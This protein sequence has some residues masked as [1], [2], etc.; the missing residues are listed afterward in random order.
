MVDKPTLVHIKKQILFIG[1][2]ILALS[3]LAQ[4]DFITSQKRYSR[5]RTAI[6]EKEEIVIQQLKEHDIEV[7]KLNMLI[8]AFK[9]EGELIVYAKND[10]DVKYT[11]VNSYK[12]C[13]NSGVLEPKRKQ[14]DYPST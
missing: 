8:I 9:A 4:S 12:I 10:S 7:A 5:I 11:R 14:G 13:S 6:S 2:N 3:A 1:F